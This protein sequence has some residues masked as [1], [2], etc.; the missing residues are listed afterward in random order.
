[1]LASLDK[2]VNSMAKDGGEGFVISRKYSDF[3]L[4]LRKGVYPYDYMDSMERFQE[5]TLQFTK[6]F[7]RQ[8]NGEGISDQD[9]E[10]AQ[11]V[12]VAF[13]MNNMGDCHNLYLQSDTL[14]LVDVFENFRNIC[15]T[16]HYELDPAHYYTS[17]GLSWDTLLKTT[18]VERELLTDYGKYLVFKKGIRCEISMVSK[19]HW[20][21]AMIPTNLT[22]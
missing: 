15:L 3:P 6:S 4:L 9:Y 16:P 20:L 17:P 5:Q 2:L 11:K 22:A 12:W 1:M 21:K 8:L 18:G 13:G 19:R 7:F 10:H 14:L